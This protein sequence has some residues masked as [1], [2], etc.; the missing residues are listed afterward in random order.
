MTER[1]VHGRLFHDRSLALPNAGRSGHTEVP[2]G[3]ADMSHDAHAPVGSVV[4]RHHVSVAY[5]SLPRTR[6]AG[7]ASR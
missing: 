1:W 5:V 2:G 3:A 4:R 6:R 7:A